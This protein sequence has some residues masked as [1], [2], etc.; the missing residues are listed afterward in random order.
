MRNEGR[1]GGKG[2]GA[3]DTHYDSYFVS[4]WFG[5]VWVGVWSRFTNST[6]VLYVLGGF[7]SAVACHRL[8]AFRFY[9]VVTLSSDTRVCGLCLGLLLLAITK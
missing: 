4:V 3:F 9:T 1:E 7:F 8:S 6:A 5:M 2:P